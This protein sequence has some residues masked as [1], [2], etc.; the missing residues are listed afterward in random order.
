MCREKQAFLLS[1]DPI[2]DNPLRVRQSNPHILN[3]DIKTEKR[4]DSVGGGKTVS[5]HTES[6]YLGK[7]PD[8]PDQCG[9]DDLVEPSLFKEAKQEKQLHLFQ[10]KIEFEYVKSVIGSGY[11][12]D[13]SRLALEDGIAHRA[14]RKE[15]A[16]S[17]CYYT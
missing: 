11:E 15:Y 1:F 2:I 5:L 12:A 17:F 10:D 4:N 14:A 6:I 16:N 3:G 8:C 7:C 9:V 13:V